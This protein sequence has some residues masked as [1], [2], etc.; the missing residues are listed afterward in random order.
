MRSKRSILSHD[1]LANESSNVVLD[2]NFEWLNHYFRAI[3][4]VKKTILSK[5][6]VKN[7]ASFEEWVQAVTDYLIS[8]KNENPLLV[9]CHVAGCSNVDTYDLSG[10]PDDH[11]LLEFSQGDTRSK[12]LSQGLL[13]MFGPDFIKRPDVS[14]WLNQEILT[15][16]KQFVANKYTV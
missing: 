11:I 16:F 9:L 8:Y 7:H 6:N 15:D 5:S 14:E 4:E 3:Q 1:K 12:Y 10:K 13:R 2:A